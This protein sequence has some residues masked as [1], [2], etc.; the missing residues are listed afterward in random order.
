MA[1]NLF[2]TSV[3]HGEG[4]TT[5]ALGVLGALSRKIKK[6]GYIKPIGRATI[7]FAG[8]GIDE[9]VILIKEACGISCYLKD[10]GPVATSGE[11]PVNF[12]SKEGHRSVMDRVEQAY[13][14]VAAGKDVVFIEGTGG[15]TGGAA[16]GVSNALLARRFQAKVLLIASGGIGQPIDEIVLNKSYYE[17]NG[18]PV[19]GVVLNKVFP[20]E[21]EAVQS[22]VKR[23]CDL[24]KVPLLGAVPHD[25]ELSWPTMQDVQE[26]LK[27]TV[28]HGQSELS[29]V[30]VGRILLGAM[31]AHNA[32]DHMQGQVVLIV[33]GDRDDLVLAALASMYLAG[34]EDFALSGII[35][36]GN[37][38]P[39]RKLRQILTR[40]AIPVIEAEQDSYTVAARV[41]NLAA[42]LTP[43]DTP[44][45][46][47]ARTLIRQHVDAS[48]ILAALQDEAR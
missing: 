14:R 15:A 34:R 42:K 8:Q 41:K 44:R 38:P 36:T 28:L 31:T 43:R 12:L 30:T 19:I 24:I 4:K 17:L 21:M 23:A 18:I 16:F 11:F 9:D 29:K 22:V 2:I 39:S 5:L 33:P 25:P 48:Q 26:E 27:G 37:I 10:M 32:L 45:L 20:N 46:E 3:R 40:T 7:D 13:D 6:V 47:R 35:L 1:S